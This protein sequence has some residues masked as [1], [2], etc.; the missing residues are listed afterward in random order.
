MLIGRSS[1]ARGRAIGRHLGFEM[2]QPR[3]QS[4]CDKLGR[5]QSEGVAIEIRHADDTFLERISL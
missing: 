5:G 4:G 2:G 1:D 3:R